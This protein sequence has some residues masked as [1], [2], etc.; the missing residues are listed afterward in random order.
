MRR[1]D[2]VLQW[3]CGTEGLARWHSLIAQYWA[4]FDTLLSV[5]PVV[6]H[7]YG[8]KLPMGSQ[9]SHRGTLGGDQ[10]THQHLLEISVC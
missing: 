7:G 4:N 6:L 9:N 3:E 8:N 10:K 2:V 5:R 1:S